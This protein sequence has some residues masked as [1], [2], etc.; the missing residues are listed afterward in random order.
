MINDFNE[1]GYVLVKNFFSSERISK[2][3]DWLDKQDLET[4]ATMWTDQEPGV[5]LAVWPWINQQEHLH[6][7]TAVDT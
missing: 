4:K 1:N 2:V 7:R 3:I 6:H 5:P